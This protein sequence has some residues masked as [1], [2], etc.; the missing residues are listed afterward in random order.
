[1]LNIFGIPIEIELDEVDV[2]A[3]TDYVVNMYG[4]GDTISQAVTEYCDVIKEYFEKLQEDEDTLGKNLTSHLHYLRSLPLLMKACD[5][6]TE[7]EKKTWRE[8]W[9]EAGS[10]H[11]H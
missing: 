9:K 2:F 4:V 10:M 3:V 1:M 11:D 6:K 7:P 5:A 8:K